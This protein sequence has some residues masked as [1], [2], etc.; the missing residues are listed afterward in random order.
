MTRDQGD[1]HPSARDLK[2]LYAAA[3]ILAR[4][5]YHS[6]ADEVY[7]LADTNGAVRVICGG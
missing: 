6:L 4:L 7:D 2:T 1:Y 5:D 3:D